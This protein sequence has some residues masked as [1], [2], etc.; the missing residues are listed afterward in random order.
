MTTP[1]NVVY[2]R[3]ERPSLSEIKR[4]NTMKNL[5]LYLFIA[6]AGAI[7]GHGSSTEYFKKRALENHAAIL[8]TKNGVTEFK[9]ND[10]IWK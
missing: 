5:L 2:S 3:Q 4:N 1:N 10:E 9:W 6:L 8:I 7:V